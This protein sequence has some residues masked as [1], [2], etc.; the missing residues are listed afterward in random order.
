MASLRTDRKHLAQSR[1]WADSC[2]ILVTSSSNSNITTIDPLGCYRVLSPFPAQS[3]TH[4]HTHTHTHSHSWFFPTPS[5]R[6]SRK[7]DTHTHTHTLTLGFSLPPP[8]GSPAKRTCLFNPF[9]SWFESSQRWEL[10][11]ALCFR[12]IWGLGVFWGFSRSKLMTG[13]LLRKQMSKPHLIFGSLECM[14]TGI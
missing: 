14:E 13:S 3:L 12:F 8:S 6:V 4:T 10:R 2:I 11:V 5:I 1:C 7:K 9:F